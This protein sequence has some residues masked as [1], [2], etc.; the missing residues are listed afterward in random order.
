MNHRVGS[1]KVLGHVSLCIHIFQST[2]SNINF[3]SYKEFALSAKLIPT[4]PSLGMKSQPG[5][6][7]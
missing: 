6:A 2:H 7:A 5:T 3:C 1:R 4:D